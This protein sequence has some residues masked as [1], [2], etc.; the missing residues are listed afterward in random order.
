MRS[1]TLGIVVILLVLSGIASVGVQA[2]QQDDPLAAAARR[3]RDDKKQ[4]P[5]AKVWDNDNIPKS[6][7][8]VSVVGHGAA[9]TSSAQTDAALSAASGP[10]PKDVPASAADRKISIQSD[11]LAAK[12]ALQTLQNDV[13]IMQR[14]LVLDQQ[15][16]FGKPGYESDKAGAAALDGEQVQIDAKQ[17][18]MQATQSKIAQLQAQL[19]GPSDPK[20]TQQ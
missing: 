18:Q 16:Y 4:Q 15:T 11:L 8:S 9:E 3:A 7:G 20:T 5:K 14:K 17:E 2:A 1:S 6:P 10:A 19:N 13:D 12:D